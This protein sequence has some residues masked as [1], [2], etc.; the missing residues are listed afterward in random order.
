MDLRFNRTEDLE[1]SWHV[2]HTGIKGRGRNALNNLN[3]TL[4]K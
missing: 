4:R 2:T 3:K 1:D